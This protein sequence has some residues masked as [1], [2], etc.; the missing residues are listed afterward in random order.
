MT[1]LELLLYV[2]GRRRKFAA[3][4]ERIFVLLLYN[5]WPCHWLMHE[6]I[7]VAV[8]AFSLWKCT[9]HFVVLSFLLFFFTSQGF[10]ICCCQIICSMAHLTLSS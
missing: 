2:F 1:I 3:R 4:Q 6:V 8:V 7:G 10:G 5:L 9:E